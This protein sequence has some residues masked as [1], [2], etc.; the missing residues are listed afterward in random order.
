[1][2]GTSTEHTKEVEELLEL[3]DLVY[4]LLLICI[5]Y[6]DQDPEKTY[7]WDTKTVLHYDSYQDVTEEEIERYGSG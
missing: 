7:R 3:P 1:M 2:I 4:P 5:G 6:P